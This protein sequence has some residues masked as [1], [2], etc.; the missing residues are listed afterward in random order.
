MK[1]ILAILTIVA[2]V[3]GNASAQDGVRE[4]GLYYR[5]GIGATTVSDWAQDLT[6]N[7]SLG[8]VL[9]CTGSCP[10][11]P[12]SLPDGN[13]V[14]NGEGFVAGAAIGFDY[15]DGIRTE[16]EYR[17]ASSN[18]EGVTQTVPAGA[19]SVLAL[20][21]VGDRAGAH[22]I[23]ANFFFDIYNDSPIT[24]FIGAGVGGALV[25]NQYGDQRL[26]IRVVR[27]FLSLWVVGFLQILNISIRARINLSLGRGWIRLLQLHPF[28]QMSAAIIMNHPP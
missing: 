28:C 26:P 3:G 12:I 9:P 18:I 4:D 2:T 22:F 1:R 7:P 20:P 6:F 14:T 13:L 8:G 23:M 16:L 10:V 11:T 24:P 5:V 19:L 21:P 25:T 15:A 27:V 17:Y